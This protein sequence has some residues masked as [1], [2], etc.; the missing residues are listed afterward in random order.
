M[1][2]YQQPGRNTRVLLLRHCWTPCTKTPITLRLD[3]P[4]LEAAPAEARR[5]GRTLTNFIEVTLRERPGMMQP[6][7]AVPVHGEAMTAS[8]EARPLDGPV[9]AVRRRS[10]S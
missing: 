8:D 9:G 4:V 2:C 6:E 7:R 3:T 10:A 1:R 5:D